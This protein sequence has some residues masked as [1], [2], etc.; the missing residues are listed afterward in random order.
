MERAP[1]VMEDQ[2][3]WVAPLEGCG[4]DISLSMGPVEVLP[5]ITAGG[6]LR[7]TIMPSLSAYKLTGPDD[8]L[9]WQLHRTGASVGEMS[10]LSRVQE[11][12]YFVPE[13]AVTYAYLHPPSTMGSIREDIKLLASPAEKFLTFGG[14]AF[15]DAKDRPLTVNAIAITT[16]SSN[17]GA[18]YNFDGPHYLPDTAAGIKSDLKPAIQ[19]GGH[20]NNSKFFSWLPPSTKVKPDLPLGGFLFCFDDES[21]QDRYF[22]ILPTDG[23]ETPS[24]PAVSL[25]AR[26]KKDQRSACE[27]VSLFRPLE[28]I[29]R[30]G[31]GTVYRAI[32]QDTGQ[33]VAMKVVSQGGAAGSDVDNEFK[34]MKNLA[35]ENIVQIFAF[36][37]TCKKA[38]I[39]MELVPYGTLR[40]LISDFGSGLPLTMISKLLH[41][42][43]RGVRY[44]HGQNTLHADL[45]PA[46]I[47]CTANGKVKLA[48]FGAA[49]S[50]T[51]STESQSGGAHTPLYCSPDALHGSFTTA[52]DVWAIGCI[53]QEM[54][55]G[56]FPWH[57]L[58]DQG[59]E[60]MT[61]MVNHIPK[62]DHPI[63]THCPDPLTD[64]ISSC[65]C[66]DIDKRATVSD[67]VQ[68]E[69]FHLTF[70]QFKSWRESE[71]K[72]GKTT[73]RVDIFGRQNTTRLN[74]DDQNG[75]VYNAPRKAAGIQ[76]VGLKTEVL[77]DTDDEDSETLGG[78]EYSQS[79][80]T[81]SETNHLEEAWKEIVHKIEKDSKRPKNRCDA[82]NFI[83]RAAIEA[84]FEGYRTPSGSMR[85]LP[86]A[87]TSTTNY[88]ATLAGNTATSTPQYAPFAPRAASSVLPETF[89]S[90]GDLDIIESIDA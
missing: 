48:D 47:L 86:T 19:L 7:L 2:G 89:F 71:K 45:K 39:I 70:E 1:S 23:S 36:F 32:R 60:L 57:H 50:L 46:N 65:M 51:Q 38:I 16:S 40:S 61:V 85:G 58:I 10:T 4:A 5:D 42:V 66:R 54:Y 8:V 52:S 26:K 3:V 68:S 64:L 6:A 87:T 72:K 90:D 30:G 41:Q 33:M 12:H 37:K 24:G 84:G 31:F 62:V 53:A 11:E 21:V 69:L 49:R 67:L 56:L 18:V 14:F 82:L 77:T 35:H 17:P 73:K 80:T 28:E 44:L 74:G 43:V 59:V 15:F 9:T 34:L 29:G 55:T 78:D 13:G 63:P 88:V 27:T 83:R 79:S 20:G 25:K 75:T 81:L 76:T 22:R